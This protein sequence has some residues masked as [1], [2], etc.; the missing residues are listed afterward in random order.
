MIILIELI[1]ALVLAGLITLGIW[2]V[3]L[4]LSRDDL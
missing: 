2:G 1:G 4:M 3:I